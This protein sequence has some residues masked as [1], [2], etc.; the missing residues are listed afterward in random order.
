MNKLKLNEDK[1]KIMEAYMNNNSDK[2]INTSNKIIE[3]M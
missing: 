2:E 3:K 1:T